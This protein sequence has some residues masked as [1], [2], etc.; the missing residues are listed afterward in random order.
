MIAFLFAHP[1]LLKIPLIDE[2]PRSRNE[3]VVKIMREVGICEKRGSGVDRIVDSAEIY[4]LPPPDFI[5]K[6]KH[7]TAIL[8]GPRPFEKMTREERIRA[9]YQHACLKYVAKDQ[10]TNQSIRARF[11]LKSNSTASKIISATVD[12]GLIIAVKQMGP[13]A[14]YVPYWAQKK[15]K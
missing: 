3:L 10:L 11:K 4:Q 1:Q 6:E 9:C 13:R 7:T 8:F 12:E 15:Q 14:S 2:M 5:A